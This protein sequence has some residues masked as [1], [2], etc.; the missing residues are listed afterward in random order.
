M[1]RI[2]KA[3]GCC[4]SLSLSLSRTIIALSSPPSFISP[5]S[6]VFPPLFIYLF[7]RHIATLQHACHDL[8]CKPPTMRTSTNPFGDGDEAP[9]PRPPVASG[10]SRRRPAPR[11][12]GGTTTAAAQPPQQQ[13]PQ[14]SSRYLQD[15]PGGGYGTNVS[16]NHSHITSSSGHNTAGNGGPGPEPIWTARGVEWPL[17]PSLRPSVYARLLRSAGHQGPSG[18]IP[19][20]ASSSSAAAAAGDGAGGDDGDGHGTAGASGG[21]EAAPAYGISSYL[22]GWTSAPGNSSTAAAGGS[23]AEEDGA[24]HVYVYV[25]AYLL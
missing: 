12:R 23:S 17:P 21:G 16:S 6:P 13:Q 18:V 22:K 2:Y 24:F 5:R 1:Y 8:V 19:G 14:Y 20:G 25:C 15:T 3:G 7:F 9:A 10:G 4:L 11:G